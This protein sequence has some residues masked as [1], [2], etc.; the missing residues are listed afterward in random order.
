MIEPSLQIGGGNWANKSDSL[1]GYHKNG[2]NFY[3]DELTF[4]RNSLAS[5]TDANGLIQSMPYNLLQQSNTFGVSPWNITDGT[6]TRGQSS[7]DGTL[8]ATLFDVSVAGGNIRQDISAIGVNNFSIYAKKGTANGIR[9]RF[10]QDSDTNLY[11]DLT[12]G[13]VFTSGNTLSINVDSVGNGWYKIDFSFEAVGL[14]LFRIIITDGTTTLSTGSIYIQDAQLNS[15][16]TA[17]PYFATTTRLN[18]ARVDYKDN[19]NGSLLLEPQRTNLALYSNDLSNAAWTKSYSTITSNAAISPD[20]T[21]N[22]NKVVETT[23]TGLHRAGQG[24]IA[25]T[26]GQVYTFSFYAKAAERDELELQRINTSGTVFNSISAT[27]ADL[28]LGTLSVGSNVTSSSIN[29][30]GD[31][32]YRISLSLTAIATGS[33]GLNI[34]MQKDGN[35]S[36]LGDGTSGVYIYGFQ[37]ELGSYVS[38]YIK[39]EGAATTRLADSC[40]KTGISD[41]IG[42]TEGVVFLDVGDVQNNGI[43][44]NQIWYF[45][46]RKD[47][48][49]SFGLASAGGTPQPVRFVTK[50]AGSVVTEGEPAPF[51]NSKVAIKYTATQF[52][53]FKNGSLV[54]TVNKNIG[55]YVDIEFMESASVNLLMILKQFLIFPSAL[56]DAEC[57][58][59][60]TL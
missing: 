10:D 27:T 47:Q 52:K 38:S 23:D 49:N 20:G 7:Y 5:Y 4:S 24:A 31:G 2:A 39:S 8:N 21:T 14:N 34:G 33:G 40:S 16:S 13:S 28:T 44:G 36:Y 46:M 12:D 60:T 57:I 19:I 58:T 15:G 26:S 25:V 32:W 9:I 43:T 1:L 18:L 37:A 56:S 22:A 50:I 54:L 41:K 55:G 6:T 11:I 3:A 59:L 29:S 51:A 35:V 45:E 30:V 17:L 42:Q 48:D 53:L